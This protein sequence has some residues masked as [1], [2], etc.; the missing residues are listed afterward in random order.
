[1]FLE[2]RITALTEDS[3]DA[4]GSAGEDKHENRTS[5]MHLEQEKPEW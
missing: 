2:I 5:M 4:K 3:N 1:M